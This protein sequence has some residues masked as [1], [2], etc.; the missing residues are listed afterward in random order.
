M[1]PPSHPADQRA[2]QTPIH[3]GEKISSHDDLPTLNG[4]K[5][6]RQRSGHITPFALA[7]DQYSG[8]LFL[9]WRR[10]PLLRAGYPASGWAVGK[11]TAR[12]TLLT[13]LQLASQSLP[14]DHRNPSASA[15][16]SAWQKWYRPNQ[17]AK[18]FSTSGVSRKRIHPWTEGYQKQF[19]GDQRNPLWFR[20]NPQLV[21]SVQLSSI[22]CPFRNEIWSL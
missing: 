20:L 21:C 4:W 12:F 1:L 14:D 18:Q 6:C 22:P 8:M 11:P 17:S 13:R 5:M 15:L 16:R 7:K 19:R 9:A 10:V 3:Q 2:D